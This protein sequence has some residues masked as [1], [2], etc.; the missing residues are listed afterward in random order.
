MEMCM[1]VGCEKRKDKLRATVT[2]YVGA[3]DQERPIRQ[4]DDGRVVHPFLGTRG[5]VESPPGTGWSVGVVQR[6]CVDRSLTVGLTDRPHFVTVSSGSHGDAVTT[7][8]RGDRS[9]FKSC[10]RRGGCLQRALLTTTMYHPAG[11]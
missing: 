8:N 4:Q 2:T 6:R 9:K 5:Q 11:R 10:E 1:S 7:V 3:G